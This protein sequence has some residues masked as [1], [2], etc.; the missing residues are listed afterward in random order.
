MV[1]TL[2]ANTQHYYKVYATQGLL[3]TDVVNI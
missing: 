2:I 3:E 1:Y